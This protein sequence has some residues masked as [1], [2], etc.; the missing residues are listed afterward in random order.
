[1]ANLLEFIRKE[2]VEENILLLHDDYVLTEP[3]CNAD[4]AK[5][6]ERVADKI[7]Y[8]RLIPYSDN[9]FNSGQGWK[10]PSKVSFDSHFNLADIDRNAPNKITRLPIS[11]QPA[12]WNSAFIKA[13]F[14]PAWSPWQQEVLASREYCANGT[15][16]GIP[17]DYQFLTT[18]NFVYAYVNGVRDGKYSREFVE[19]VE[20]TPELQPFHFVRDVAIPVE[21]LGEQR[22]KTLLSRQTDGTYPRERYE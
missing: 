6:E 16:G 20:H 13:F 12:I 22:F 14:N 17:C 2:N 5:A 3:V 19:L 7:G 21:E 10:W 18:R 8:V 4:V 1:V 11:H 9:E 15:I